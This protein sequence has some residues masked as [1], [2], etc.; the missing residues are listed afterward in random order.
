MRALLLALGSSGGRP[1]GATQR[2]GRLCG[3]LL[4][5]D[6]GTHPAPVP[7]SGPGHPRVRAVC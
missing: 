7:G 3:A 4:P 5:G 1:G 6:R 2:R